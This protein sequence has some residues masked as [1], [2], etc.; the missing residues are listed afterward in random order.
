MIVI[1]DGRQLNEYDYFT[2]RGFLTVGVIADDEIRLD[3]LQ[4]RVN[5]IIDPET[6]QHET[7]EQARECVKKC[8]IVIGNNGNHN[9]LVEEVKN[10]LGKYLG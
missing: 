4:K 1:D 5:Y 6:F 10:K 9:S 2:E 8:K 3:R 7:E